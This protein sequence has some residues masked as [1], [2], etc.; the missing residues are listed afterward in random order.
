MSVLN[1]GEFGSDEYDAD[2]ALFA[3]IADLRAL[4]DRV[5]E[6]NGNGSVDTHALG[7][8]RWSGKS[9]APAGSDRI[10][11]RRIEPNRGL[12]DGLRPGVANRPPVGG[13]GYA[14]DRIGASSQETDRSAGVEDRHPD[15]HRRRLDELARRLE[16]RAVRSRGPATESI[17]EANGDSGEKRTDS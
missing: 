3:A 2:E 10:G 5:F 8:P 13:V 16:S 9:A 7:E 14:L 12:N 11:A 6:A 1:G 4:I 17:R 15:D